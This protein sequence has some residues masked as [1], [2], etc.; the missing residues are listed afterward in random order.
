MENVR[1]LKPDETEKWN[2]FLAKSPQGTLFHR[3]DWNQMLADTEPQMGGFLALVCVD[4]KD[5]FLAALTVPRR[6]ASSRTSS[7]SPSFGYVS[8]LLADSLGYAERHH[9]YSSYTPLVDLTKSLVERVPTV[10]INNSPAIWD[11]RSYMFN[12]WK[13]ETVYTHE[14]LRAEDAWGRVSPDL[15][16]ILQQ[17]AQKFS[18]QIA[19]DEKWEDLFAS[20]HPQFDATILKKRLAWMRANETGR[21]YALTDPQNQPVAF[22]LAM[23]S[24][25]DGRAYLWGTS[26]PDADTEA[27]LLWQVCSA[28]AADF[29]RID[30]GYSANIQISQ[31]KDKLGGKLLPTF[32]TSYPK[33]RK[34]N[35]S[36]PDGSE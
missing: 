1:E 15:Q 5:D 9:T 23:L 19:T 2:A 34:S 35:K 28:L 32:V 24:Q 30:L 17:G 20:R 8:P 26:S 18:L 25:P 10:R 36:Q 21:L 33:E 31:M 27:I 7:G 13:I 11:I 3:L 22:T 12:Q 16:P 14:Y 4:K 6:P 29:P